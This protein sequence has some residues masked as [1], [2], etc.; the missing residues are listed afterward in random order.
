MTKRTD[1]FEGRIPHQPPARKQPALLSPTPPRTAQLPELPAGARLAVRLN[2]GDPKCQRTLIEVFAIDDELAELTLV[3]RTPPGSVGPA[4]GFAQWSLTEPSLTVKCWEHED[5][6]Y[7]KV[8]RSRIHFARELDEFKRC[9]RPRPVVV[10]PPS[11]AAGSG[12]QPEHS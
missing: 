6:R 11:R 7:A 8:Q 4:G 12:H 5:D 10:R 3:A 2:C 1:K 9:G